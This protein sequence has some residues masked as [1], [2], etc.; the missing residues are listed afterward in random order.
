M[1]AN[2]NALPRVALSS[3]SKIV[4]WGTSVIISSS[5]SERHPENNTWFTT[6][7]AFFGIMSHSLH[8]FD[9]WQYTCLQTQIGR[10][11]RCMTTH[12]RNIYGVVWESRGGE[13]VGKRYPSYAKWRV[14]RWRYCC[15]F[16]WAEMS[17]EW[18]VALTQTRRTSVLEISRVFIVCW[19]HGLVHRVRAPLFHLQI[20]VLGE[21]HRAPQV[22]PPH[23]KHGV[24]LL[25]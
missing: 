4:F 20:H 25:P 11:D 2:P 23:K 14:L 21:V 15:T 1:Y 16:F 10:I 17:C 6:P 24:P 13:S 9:F 18:C 5:S 12:E 3:S 8:T 22:T 7:V 19:G